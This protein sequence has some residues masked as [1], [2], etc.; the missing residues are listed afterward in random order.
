M[1]LT[2]PTAGGGRAGR[3]RVGM[4][5]ERVSLPSRPGVSRE[6]DAR[7]ADHVGARRKRR[8]R[9]ERRVGEGDGRG[10]HR[11]VAEMESVRERD[12]GER[13]RARGRTS[14]V[15]DE[16]LADDPRA[17]SGEHIVLV[18]YLG[19]SHCGRGKGGSDIEA[20]RGREPSRL[21]RRPIVA[22]T[23]RHGGE[24]RRVDALV[25]VCPLRVARLRRESHARAFAPPRGAPR[26]VAPSTIARAS[27][28]CS[29]YSGKQTLCR[30]ASG[31]GSWIR[32][33]AS[34]DLPMPSAGAVRD[35]NSKTDGRKYRVKKS[36]P[37]SFSAFS[38]ASS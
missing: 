2:A 33:K 3:E 31:L 1:A 4:G 12:E 7:V 22:R 37:Q 14:V 16:D 36:T 34:V 35:F 9:R 24:R 19:S 28:G 21:V 15:R 27:V 5:G 8:E 20:R 25:P 38:V 6:P 32:R 11:L 29:S 30:A 13:G 23:H 10:H 26:V 17:S 18:L